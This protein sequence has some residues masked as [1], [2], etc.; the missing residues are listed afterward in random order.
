MSTDTYKTI[1]A[2]DI[3]FLRSVCA[4]ER[5]V[6]GPAVGDDYCH[7]ELSGI[8]RRPDVLVKAA[9]TQEVAAVMKYAYDHTIPVTPRGQGTGLVGGAVPLFGG[10][11]LDLSGMN[12]IIELDEDNLTLTLEPGVLLM[13][14]VKYVEERGFLY[15]PDPG[16]KS[17][18]IGGNISTNA[19]GMRA[20]K[21]GVT[22]DYVRGLEVV[23]PN[24]EITELGGKVVKN[25]SGYSLKDLVVGSEGTLA[26]VTKAILRLLPL[27]KHKISLLVPFPTL[28]AAIQTVPLVLR[29]S[30]VPT[31]VEFMEREVILA[32]EEF[33]G[34]KFPDNSADAY[35]LLTFDAASPAELELAYTSA[36][37]I[38]LEAGALDVFLSNTQ[39][40]NES[41][42][43][44]RG[45]FLEAIKA[46]TTE[47]D[48]CDVVVPRRHVAEFIL[49]AH[50]LQGKHHIRIRSFGH[51]GDGNLHIYILRDDLPEDEWHKRL[52]AVF[53]DLYHKAKEFGGQVSGEH[54]IGFAKKPYLADSLPPA[55]LA[56]M[57]AIKR[58]F[59][60]K[61]ILNPAKIIVE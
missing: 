46:S 41:I 34:R 50:A 58:A 59:D 61:N 7:D 43:S 57:A 56:L 44:A 20:V 42:W 29:A 17:A 2:A 24:G 15:P 28:P 5:V 55:N 3:E 11:L 47:M 37:N 21:Y 6:P 33:L 30:S 10:I 31:A 23:L 35:L 16:E 12:R 9:S 32:S 4:P 45:A 60:P 40:R 18:T 38:C 51:A 19:G 53:H 26:I 52:E 22:R 49:F 14:V 39:E 54:G 1:D 48:E 25:S 13:E 27:P 8:R 36:A